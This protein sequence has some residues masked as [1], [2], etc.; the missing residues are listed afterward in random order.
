MDIAVAQQILTTT[1]KS[2]S[3]ELSAISL[4]LSI[5]NDTFKAEFDNLLLAQTEA[6]TLAQQLQAEKAKVQQL[7]KDLSDAKL[8]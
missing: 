7:T 6:N 4:A 5:L 8:N 2:K 3:D 1:I